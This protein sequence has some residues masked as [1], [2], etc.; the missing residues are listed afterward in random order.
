[1][2]SPSQLWDLLVQG[3]SG[4]G[5]VPKER[6][7]ASGFYHPDPSRPGSLPSVGGYFLQHDVR[8]F[9]NAFFGLNNLEAKHIDPQQR[10]LLEVV[11]ECLENGGQPLAG[12]SGSNTGCFVANFTNDYSMMQYKD[13]EYSS[14]YSG[15]GAAASI[16][17]NRLN[18]VFDLHGPSSVTDT[19]CSSSL[20]SLH[21]ACN[22]LHGEDCDAAI[23]ASAN[24]I[25]SPEQHLQAVKAGI[26]SPDSVCHTYDESANGYGR[27]EGV[28][29]L[30]LK[31]LDDALRDGDPIRSIIRGTAVNRSE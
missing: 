18:H 11:Y 20:Y 29:A 12:I 13:V 23:V 7:N 21:S 3:R 19:A 9:D 1:V 8:K 26:L 15:T 10:Q 28:S 2:N 27:A 30:F 6:F 22:A 5:E 25:Q 16:L 17:A 24:L 4:H 31:R 14:H